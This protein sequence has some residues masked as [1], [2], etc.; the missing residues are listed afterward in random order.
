MQAILY[1]IG[2]RAI[3]NNKAYGG[4]SNVVKGEGMHFYI[5]FF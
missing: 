1:N 4:I 5:P 3:V 2:E